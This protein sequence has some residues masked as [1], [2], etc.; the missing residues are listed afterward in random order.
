MLITRIQVIK[1]RQ[2][3]PENIKKKR[4]TTITPSRINSVP[5]PQTGASELLTS[6]SD[7][8]KLMSLAD[9]IFGGKLTSILVCQKCKHVSQTYEDFN[10][11]SLSIKAEDYHE[12]K[13]DRIKNLA[14]RLTSFPTASLAMGLDVPRSSSVPPSPKGRETRQL[15]G[16]EEP[17]IAD[18]PRRRSID[19][20]ADQGQDVDSGQSMTSKEEVTTT[21]EDSVVPINGDA[22]DK[23]AHVAVLPLTKTEK[24]KKDSWTKLGKR[25]SMTVGLRKSSKERMS[26]SRDRSS[27][28][29][30]SSSTQVDPSNI[31]TY[32]NSNS[33][34]NLSRNSDSESTQDLGPSIVL[35]P[36]PS[37]VN[38]HSATGNAQAQALCS[39]SL[40]CDPTSPQI[41]HVQRGKSPKPPKPSTAELSYLREI[42]ADVTPSPMS[43]P[44]T[45]FKHQQNGSNRPVSAGPPGSTQN[46]W[47]SM[48]HFSGIEECLRMFTSVEIMDGDNMVGC[49]RC[50]KI[51]NG[52]YRQSVE[53]DDESDSVNQSGTEGHPLEVPTNT[54]KPRSALLPLS[55]PLAH[56]PTSISTPTVSFYSH[57]N[58]SDQRSVS[59]LPTEV[60]FPETDTDANLDRPTVRLIPNN[61]QTP[62]LVASVQVPLISTTAPDSLTS[63][64]HYPQ[65]LSNDVPPPKSKD[66][67]ML[68]TLENTKL[69]VAQPIPRL[70]QVLSHLPSKNS[71]PVPKAQ[72]QYRSDLEIDESSGAE[73]E[74]SIATSARSFES[75]TSSH[76]HM[77]V[78][79]N[80]TSTPH[81]VGPRKASRPKPVIMRPA[82]KRY[83]ISTPPPVLVIHLKRFQQISKTHII[84]FSHGF[85][86]LDDYVTFPEFLDLTPYL[87]PKKEDFGL[88][89]NDKVKSPKKRNLKHIDKCVYRLYAVVV[90]IGNMV[91]DMSPGRFFVNCS[92]SELFSPAWWSLYSVRCFTRSS[93]LGEPGKLH[94]PDVQSFSWGAPASSTVGLC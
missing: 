36:P 54:R 38:D 33:N 93:I 70:G 19:V 57:S 10:D 55:P 60:S 76:V 58:S 64:S 89:K 17:P 35:S 80:I 61:G 94:R 26:R 40:S 74:T 51:A 83:L 78:G 43:N 50:W 45:L 68:S 3:P 21:S 66:H 44:F 29:Y 46:L 28:D 49:R 77:G 88:G 2:P 59:S 47:L 7:E 4:R 79:Q 92:L 48:S 15:G 25:I 42:L 23:E 34:A 20:V 84:S 53:E 8:D 81:S 27:R 30:T 52:V 63:H 32:E 12:R 73:S 41:S 62:T 1:K 90:H 18:G 56:I 91:R 72:A 31:R 82:Y 85:K 67:F 69:P 71:L 11:I 39:P 87:A 5:P 22:S 6:T 86:K 75:S 37:K 16:H 65:A 14:K 13:R 9:M 24:A